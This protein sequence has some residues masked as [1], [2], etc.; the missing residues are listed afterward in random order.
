VTTK[1]LSDQIA[2]IRKGRKI[3][4]KANRNVAAVTAHR[5][6]GAGRYAVHAV[7]KTQTEVR[8]LA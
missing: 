7:S 3:T 4:V 6:L 5:R 8:H 2:G 1:T